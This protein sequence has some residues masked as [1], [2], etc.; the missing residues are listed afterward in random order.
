MF[1]FLKPILEG[2]NYLKS[3]FR[4]NSFLPPPTFYIQNF[5]PEIICIILIGRLHSP[6]TNS[7]LNYVSAGQK[8]SNLLTCS[9]LNWINVY[10]SG[11]GGKSER[12][13]RV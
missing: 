5:T 2:A 11:W 4:V 6:F 7:V 1:I 10:A 8:V 13:S 9:S 12:E 3:S